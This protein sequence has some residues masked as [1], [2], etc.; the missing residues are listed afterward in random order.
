MLVSG[1]AG[2]LL[3]GAVLPNLPAGCVCVCFSLISLSNPISALLLGEAK[4]LSGSKEE[5]A[6]DLV[7]DPVLAFSW[8]PSLLPDLN[9]VRGKGHKSAVVR[10]YYEEINIYQIAFLRR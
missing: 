1:L 5:A 4:V 9:S 6:P 8:S 10:I 3:P 7:C 2:G